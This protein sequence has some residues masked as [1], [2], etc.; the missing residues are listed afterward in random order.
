[1][2]QA[3]PAERERGRRREVPGSGWQL[4]GTAV[5]E[6]RLTFTAFLTAFELCPDSVGSGW[7]P[8]RLLP[9]PC[10]SAQ[11]RRA[12]CSM[13]TEAMLSEGRGRNTDTY[14]DL[15]PSAPLSV[16]YANSLS[17]NVC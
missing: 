9:P 2:T 17:A 16:N 8:G 10:P 5:V 6:S 7:A 15:V 11:C 12:L 4:Q 3:W 1:M 13:W 14:Q